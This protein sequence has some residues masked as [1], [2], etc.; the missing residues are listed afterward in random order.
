[1][2]EKR[3][4]LIIICLFLFFAIA[5]FW[6]AT[7]I[8]TETQ[9][10]NR[11]DWPDETA[12]YFW[13]DHFS[14]TG[15]L[16]VPES[17]NQPAQNQIHPRSFNVRQDGSLVPGS[18][19]GLIILFG[20]IAKGF[21][22][23]IIIYLTPA[24]AL[25]GAVCW[26]GII[27]HLF[28]RK[29]AGIATA[30]LLFHPAWWYY[31]VTSLLPNVAFVSLILI[32][33]FLFLVAPKYHHALARK[34]DW[35][36][37]SLSA[38][39]LGIAINIRPSEIIWVSFLFIILWWIERSRIKIKHLIIF[40]VFFCLPFLV[41]GF[42]QQNIYGNFLTS[43]YDQLHLEQSSCQWCEV[44]KSLTLPF[45]FHPRLAYD[46]AWQYIVIMF[47]PWVILGVVGLLGMIKQSHHQRRPFL[48]Y[49]PVTI[50]LAAWLVIYYGS[51]QFD[52]VMTLDLNSL[53]VSYVRYWLA[54]YIAMLPF[55]ALGIVTISH[56]FKERW[57]KLAIGLII[58][59]LAGYSAYQTLYSAQDSIM[60]VRERIFSYKQVS[61]EVIEQ[62]PEDSVIITQRKDKV[63]FPD[64]KV[65]HRFKDL[66]NDQELW[67]IIVSLD[68]FVPVY[69][70]A[71]APVNN[72]DFGGLFELSI[73]KTI[74]SEVLYEIIVLN[75]AQTDQ[76]N[77]E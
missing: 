16:V 68:A 5:Y 53:G 26:Y 35:L 59:V 39:I 64:R 9:V 72:N 70:F 18:F 17:L 23:W 52:D 15:E 57:Q 6:L 49:L 55:V 48:F 43:G 56:V 27:N 37:F 73:L 8:K 13:I 1:M 45:G 19:L 58:F 75:P 42:Y 28:N 24:L 4:R 54:L 31:S 25:L 36:I 69:Y 33:L 22:S 20:L 63:L 21:G 65:I 29:I 7:P 12:N 74:G 32:S 67:D 61:Q 11:F 3:Q 44:V 60:P 76:Q 77:E 10:G 66:E 40:G 38:L 14:K 50:L 30:L 41:T 46:M 2:T 71:L 34:G 47:L 51:W 62:T